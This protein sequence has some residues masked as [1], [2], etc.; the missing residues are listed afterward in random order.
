[1]HHCEYTYEITHQAPECKSEDEER[2]RPRARGSLDYDELLPA[3]YGA[4][5]SKLVVPYLD[6]TDEAKRYAD[7]AMAQLAAQTVVAG[8][9]SLWTRFLLLHC[10][11]ICS[12]EKNDFVKADVLLA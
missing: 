4:L 8:Q 9:E 12:A 7:S 5:A 3:G 2:A 6:R 11:A 1:V 10:K